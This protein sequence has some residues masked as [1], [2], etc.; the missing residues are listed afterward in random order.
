MRKET[1]LLLL[2]RAHAAVNFEILMLGDSNRGPVWFA[3][4]L[5]DLVKERTEIDAAIKRLENELG[6]QPCTTCGETHK[7]GK[8]T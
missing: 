3:A 5:R 2:K 1:E 7:P 4:Q 8:S 6:P